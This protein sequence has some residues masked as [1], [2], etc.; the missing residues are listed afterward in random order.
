MFVLNHLTFSSI[1]LQTNDLQ[2]TVSTKQSIS[3]Q[4]HILLYSFVIDKK[5]ASKRREHVNVLIVKN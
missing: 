2:S 4:N 3:I 5:L 1:Y